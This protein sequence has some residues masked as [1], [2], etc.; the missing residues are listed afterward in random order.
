MALWLDLLVTW[1]DPL[2]RVGIRDLPVVHHMLGILYIVDHQEDPIVTPQDL[3]DM[4]S[5]VMHLDP[6]V[7]QGPTDPHNMVYL[8]TAVLRMLVLDRL[9]STLKE[10]LDHQ[11]V[12]ADQMAGLE[13]HLLSKPNWSGLPFSIK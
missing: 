4:D 8:H 12:R 9:L 11:L 3:L 1:V 13:L 7:I 5:L 6:M 2:F 10:H